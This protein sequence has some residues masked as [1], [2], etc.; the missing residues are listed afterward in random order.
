[1]RPRRRPPVPRRIVFATRDAL[2]D[3]ARFVAHARVARAARSRCRPVG[4]RP[5]AAPRARAHG[6][7]HSPRVSRGGRRAGG[8]GGLRSL[9]RALAASG[10]PV[11]FTPGVVH[12]PTV[13]AYRK[14]NRI[15]MGTADKVCATALAVR[16]QATAAWLRRHRRLAHSP[17]AGRRVLGRH[18]GRARSD[19]RWRR[20]IVRADRRSGGR[21][22]RWRS[23]VPRRRGHEGAC[24]SRAARQ[25][26]RG[27]DA[28][29]SIGSP[30][31]TRPLAKIAWFAFMEGAVKAVATLLVS[32]PSAREVVISGRMA[33]FDRVRDDLVRRLATRRAAACDS[34]AARVREG[35][36]AGRAGRGARRRTGSRAGEKRSSCSTMG[37]QRA[38]GTVLDHLAFISASSRA[39]LDSGSTVPNVAADRRRRVLIAGVSTRAMAESAARAGYAV[40]ALDAFGDL[41][42]HPGVRALSLPRDSASRSAPEAAARGGGTSNADAVAYLSPFENHPAAVERLADG[43][44][45]WGNSTP[46]CCDAVRDPRRGRRMLPR[47]AAL[48][49]TALARQAARLGRRAWNSVVEAR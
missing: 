40:T 8:I 41:D 17:R 29:T 32:A 12:L 16:D 10:L 33:A 7:R 45:L 27:E 19:R 22:A 13:P 6:R 36:E 24:C 48:P 26:S 39:R 28:R 1:M 35:R 18:R 34:P 42:Q 44:A 4:V 21:R 23:G 37:I 43:R 47:R 9:A 31:P 20:R 11:V 3:P 5:A 46:R 30:R 25:R 49:M 38:S 14:V 2:A 15:D